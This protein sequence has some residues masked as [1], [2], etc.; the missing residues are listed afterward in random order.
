MRTEVLEVR[1]RV[2]VGLKN[3]HGLTERRSVRARENPFPNPAAENT[4]IASANEV[5]EPAAGITHGTMNDFS[6]AGVIGN[7]HVFQHSHG[8]E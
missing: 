2:A 8:N 6:Q 7:G 3:V 4:F 5:E 1:D